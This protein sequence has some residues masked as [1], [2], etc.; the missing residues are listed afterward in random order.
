MAELLYERRDFDQLLALVA[1]ERGLDPMLV[2]K[3]SLKARRRNDSTRRAIYYSRSSASCSATNP[4][5][6]IACPNA[7]HPAAHAKW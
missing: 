1:D 6:R 3:D 4:A 7:G 5:S 2:E